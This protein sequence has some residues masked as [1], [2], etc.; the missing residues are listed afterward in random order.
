MS[1]TLTL[2]GWGGQGCS[3]VIVAR[4]KLGLSAGVFVTFRSTRNYGYPSLEIAEVRSLL[5]KME[6]MDTEAIPTEQPTPEAKPWENCPYKDSGRCQIGNG[7]GDCDKLIEQGKC[8]NVNDKQPTP[9]AKEVAGEEPQCGHRVPLAGVVRCDM[10]GIGTASPLTSCEELKG[11]RECPMKVHE[12]AEQSYLDTKPLNWKAD[13]QS[14]AGNVNTP[15]AKRLVWTLLP[16]QLIA[17]SQA[18]HDI[19]GPVQYRIFMC[20]GRWVAFCGGESITNGTLTA[21]TAACEKHERTN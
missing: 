21:C 3:V 5:T 10:S 12:P 6:A 8:W 13:D 20:D 9:T 2:D 16:G 15:D 19:E 11:R 17:A 1:E 4:D 7:P 14:I 18:L